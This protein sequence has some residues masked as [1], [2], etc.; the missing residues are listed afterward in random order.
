MTTVLVTGGLGTIGSRMVPILRG[1]GYDVKVLDNKIQRLEDYIRADVCSMVEVLQA[2]K[3]WDI[4]YVLHLAGEVGRE[5]GELFARRAVD[6]NV[7]GTINLIQL[8][9][10]YGARLIYASSSEVYG[11]IGQ[12]VMREDMI[13]T[14]QTNCY[15]ISKWQAEQYI[16][17]FVQNY[18]LHAHIVRIF[19]CYGP[20]EYPSY[21][22]SAIARFV[23]NILHDR[24]V[25]VHRGASRSWCYIDDIVEGWRLVMEHFRPGQAEVYNIGRH[26]PR[27]ME[28]VAQHICRLAGKPE[29][30][31][32]F[33]DAPRFVMATKNASF[34]KAKAQL[35]FEATT[36][37]EAGLRRTIDWQREFVTDPNIEC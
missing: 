23:Y 32:E 1:H 12:A 3:Q 2:F 15:A 10:E 17:H 21:F 34:E 28:E 16:R 35:G 30:L 24:P 6:I 20:G 36:P 11:D 14:G 29:S 13:P 18:D 9:R 27:S 31:V 5:N 33:T 26:E 22:R 37:L 19:M 8:C 25:F 7:G 4:D